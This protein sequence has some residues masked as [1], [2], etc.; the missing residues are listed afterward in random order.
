M[1]SGV[2]KMNKTCCDACRKEIKDGVSYIYGYNC[3]FDNEICEAKL[4]LRANKHRTE[5]TS[6]KDVPNEEQ[7]REALKIVHGGY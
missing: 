4:T 5:K 7:V 3:C 1:T 2:M 6:L